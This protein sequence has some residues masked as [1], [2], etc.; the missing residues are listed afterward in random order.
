V[1]QRWQKVERLY[2]TALELA[3]TERGVFL[4]QDCGA[5]EELRREVHP[6]PRFQNLLRRMGL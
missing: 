1:T 6:D 3:E 5:D 4:A 2:H